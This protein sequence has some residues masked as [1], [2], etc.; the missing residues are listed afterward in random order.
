MQQKLA[1]YNTPWQWKVIQG[2][3]AKRH[4]AHLF[5]HYISENEFTATVNDRAFVSAATEKITLDRKAKSV[6]VERTRTRG[7]KAARIL[8]EL[9]RNG[10]LSRLMSGWP[11]HFTC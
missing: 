3:V 8:G 11:I 10:E 5:L 4:I 6:C 1:A 9:W 7:E 2:E